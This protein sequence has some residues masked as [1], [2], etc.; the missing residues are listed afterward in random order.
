MKNLIYPDP[1][2]NHKYF[3]WKATYDF[4]ISFL[5]K[6]PELRVGCEV[7]TCAG[8][9][10]KHIIEN[11][12]NIKKMYGVD[13]Y[14]KDNWDLKDFVSVEKEFGG[15]DSLYNEVK[16]MLGQ[17]GN[18]VELIRKPSKLAAL[19]FDDESLDFVFIDAGHEFN[20]CYDDIVSWYPKVK[21]N[22]LIMGH[23][24]YNSACMGVSKAV[25][26]FFSVDNIDTYLEPVHIYICKKKGRNISLINKVKNRF[27]FYK[28]HPK[29]FLNYYEGINLKN[30]I[31]FF[32][33]KKLLSFFLF[34]N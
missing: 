3:Y 7:G 1:T 11:C 5:N 29:L 20:D 24:F 30:K 26:K 28:K 19:D 2:R 9:N 31:K 12:Q 22:G 10:I 15:F 16:T 8:Q 34:K 14:S 18:K 4:M 25:L 33:K 27:L 23:D 13:S 21:S 32:L 6:N 17:F